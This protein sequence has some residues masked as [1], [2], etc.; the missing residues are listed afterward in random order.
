[1]DETIEL[2]RQSIITTKSGKHCLKD[3][4]G[5]VF[6]LTANMLVK[7]RCFN[8]EEAGEL[9][10]VAECILRKYDKMLSLS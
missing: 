2:V 10:G 9:S 6:E 1:M 7:D 4:S 3:F 5:E 8:K